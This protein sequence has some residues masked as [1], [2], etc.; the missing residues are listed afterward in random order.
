MSGSRLSHRLVIGLI[1]SLGTGLAACGTDAGGETAAGGALGDGGAPASSDVLQWTAITLSQPAG[2]TSL[3]LG[4]LFN[5]ALRKRTII[6][7]TKLD[8]EGGTIEAGS[9][10]VVSRPSLIRPFAVNNGGKRLSTRCVAPG[11]NAPVESEGS[12]SK[13]L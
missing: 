2:D 9:G 7:L 4:A 1:A 13:P 11:K 12:P 8:P 6:L 10:S 3:V 5:D